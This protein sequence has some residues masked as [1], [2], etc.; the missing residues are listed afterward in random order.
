MNTKKLLW[1][2]LI[3]A[4]VITI[5]LIAIEQYY[6]AVALIIGTLIMR[7]RELWSLIRTRKL[8]PVDERVRENT[9]KA[10]RN[11][12]I[13]F[14]AATAFLMLPFGV[15]LTEGP[16]TVHV[17]AGLFLSAGLVYLLS[18]L[19]YDRV[20]PKVAE[21]RLKMLKTFL[22]IAAI[23]VGAFIISVFLHNAL[24]GL[25]GVEEPVFFCIAVFVAPVALA[26]GLV[27]SL[28]L[29]IMGLAA[30]SS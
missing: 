2:V 17:L 18:Y 26:V 28:V 20:E 7:H 5:A 25:F 19:F 12:F 1:A 29:L 30:K 23:S 11:G 27:G 15:I 24:S 10:I 8:P 13:Y 16:D 22:L 6:V 21:R 4:V 14:A 3:I 9:G